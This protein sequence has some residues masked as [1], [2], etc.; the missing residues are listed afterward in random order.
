MQHAIKVLFGAIIGMALSGVSFAETYPAQFC[1]ERIV[2]Q[3][4]LGYS[5]VGIM[6]VG[7]RTRTTPI[8]CP[9]VRSK[10][11]RN[12]DID[13]VIYFIEDGISKTCTFD[14]INLNNGTVWKFTTKTGTRRLQHPRLTGAFRFLPL[15]F[16][17]ELPRFS[18]VSGYYINEL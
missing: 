18:Q 4:N 12:G 8:V 11:N 1:Q 10:D 7:S 13:P 5:R 15:A 9:V 16:N 3:P 2:G 6:N 14:V 17:C